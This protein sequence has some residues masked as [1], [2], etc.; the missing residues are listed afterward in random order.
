MESH[1]E[2]DENA[3]ASPEKIPGTNGCGR[4]GLR[5]LLEIDTGKW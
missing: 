3:G 2:E 4:Y 5:T 1:L